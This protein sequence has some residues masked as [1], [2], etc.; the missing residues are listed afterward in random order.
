[1]NDVQ[2]LSRKNIQPLFFHITWL[3]AFQTAL[4]CKINPEE[5]MSNKWQ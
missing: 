4:I 5:E 2:G 3:H 1:M